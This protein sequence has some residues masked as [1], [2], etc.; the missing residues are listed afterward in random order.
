MKRASATNDEHHD[1]IAQTALNRTLY[2][3]FSANYGDQ[4][5]A[6]DRNIS[7]TRLVRTTQTTD[8]QQSAWRSEIA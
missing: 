7:P 2:L 1:D 3:A 4:S 5:A 8:S 6:C